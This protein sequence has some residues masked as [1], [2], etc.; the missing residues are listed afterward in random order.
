[1][2]TRLK[3]IVTNIFVSLIAI[4][5]INLSIDAAEFEPLNATNDIG[6]FN[7][8]NSMVE[9]ITESILEYKDAFPEYYN[10]TS[11]SKK[12][13]LEKSISFKFSQSSQIDC[14]AKYFLVIVKNFRIDDEDFYNLHYSEIIPPPPKYNFSL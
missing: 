9:Y 13:Q 5:V 8:F 14:S 7:Y 4:Q 1:M 3:N 11:S 2:K 6:N 10:N 12:A